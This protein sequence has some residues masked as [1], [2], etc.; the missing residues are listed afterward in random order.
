[1][2]QR[3]IGKLMLPQISRKFQACKKSKGSF[4]GSQQPVIV[5]LPNQINPFNITNVFQTQI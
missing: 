3:Y 1:M 5:S 4:P 2:E